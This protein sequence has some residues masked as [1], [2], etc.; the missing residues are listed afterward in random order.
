MNTVIYKTPQVFI[1]DTLHIEILRAVAEKQGCPIRY[2][3]NQ[4]INRNSERLIRNY[5]HELLAKRYLD[6]G[7]P[8][9]NLNLRLT[10]K[11]RI[12]LQQTML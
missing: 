10:S 4:L 5:I 1:P 12:L 7:S 2:V 8:T 9:N 6:E 3:V 11:G